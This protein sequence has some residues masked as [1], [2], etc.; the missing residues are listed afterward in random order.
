M[1]NWLQSTNLSE[2]PKSG[3]PKNFDDD[4]FRNLGRVNR[5]MPDSTKY[6]RP[7]KSEGIQLE[8]PLNHHYTTDLTSQVITI[9]GS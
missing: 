8:V 4:I 1:V 3:R 2:E 7:S 5:T 9:T 6:E